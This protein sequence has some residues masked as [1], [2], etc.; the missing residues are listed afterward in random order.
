MS[1]SRSRVSRGVGSGVDAIQRRFESAQSLG[2]RVP[3]RQLRHV[4]DFETRCLC[5]GIEPGHAMNQPPAP[6]EVGHAASVRFRI[7]S[8]ARRSR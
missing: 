3:L 1:F 5:Q 7:E 6:A 4:I 8:S 2:M